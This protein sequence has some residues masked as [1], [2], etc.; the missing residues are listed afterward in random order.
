MAI[1]GSEPAQTGQ[2]RKACETF[3]GAAALAAALSF[4]AAAQAQ[5]LII[6]NDEKLAFKDGKPY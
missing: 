6:G 4:S 1:V 3:F 2:G 5:Y